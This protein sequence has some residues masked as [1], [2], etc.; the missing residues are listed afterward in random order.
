MQKLCKNGKNWLKHVR[1]IRK[2]VRKLVY[3]RNKLLQSLKSL[4][5]FGTDE[6]GVRR[7]FPLQ[8]E[9]RMNLLDNL[10]KIKEKGYI[11]NFSV[12]RINRRREDKEYGSDIELTE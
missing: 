12:W 7:I 6:N 8:K 10:K 9:D 5:D 2:W 1:E 11:N 3:V 4:Q